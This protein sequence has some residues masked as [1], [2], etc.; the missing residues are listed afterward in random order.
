MLATALEGSTGED[1]LLDVLGVTNTSIAPIDPTSSPPGV[2][3]ASPPL[4]WGPPGSRSR[5]LVASG[6]DQRPH[7]E[8]GHA[9][10]GMFKVQSRRTLTAARSP[11]LPFEKRSATRHLRQNIVVDT[12]PLPACTAPHAQAC[13]G[14]L[15]GELIACPHE[16]AIEP[17][18]SAPWPRRSLRLWPPSRA[19][20]ATHWSAMRATRGRRSWR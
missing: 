13:G 10:T 5:G 8:P 18:R 20:H 1:H 6:P 16:R 9:P 12:A 17:P 2:A 11:A 3:I 14:P 15:A 19:T 7:R 4:P